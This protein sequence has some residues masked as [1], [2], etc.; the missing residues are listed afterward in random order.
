MKLEATPEATEL[1]RARGGRL[2]V[3]ASP[4]ACCG[5]TRFIEASPS[6]PSGLEG[7]IQLPADGFDLFVRPVGSRVLPDELNV[8]LH[9]IRH[10]RVRASWN[11]C[12]Y[13]V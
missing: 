2:W 3:W 12:A 5:G 13:L 4:R 1:I 8:D 11:G 9:G 6:P 10:R 7:F